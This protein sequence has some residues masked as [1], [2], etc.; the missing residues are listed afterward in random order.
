[1]RIIAIS[2]RWPRSPVT[3]PD[4]SPSIVARPSSS[5]P[6]SAKNEIAASSDSTT[7]PMLSIRWS[8]IGPFSWRAVSARR[9]RLDVRAARRRR[10]EDSAV[11]ESTP[12]PEWVL[13]ELAHA[14]LE[15]LD[16]AYVA[17]YDRKSPTRLDGG[18]PEA[19]GDGNWCPS[20]VVDL[21]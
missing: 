1:M 21:G 5:R 20:T 14:G 19:P 13:D 18:H 16:P 11:S 15:H 8:A 2:T 7:M 17:E 3:R 9:A 12:Q 4:Q 10:C 6:S